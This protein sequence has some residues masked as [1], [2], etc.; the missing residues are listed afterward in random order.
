MSPGLKARCTTIHNTSPHTNETLNKSCVTHTGDHKWLK[1][2]LDTTQSLR[3][4]QKLFTT[5]PLKPQDLNLHAQAS[6]TDYRPTGFEPML[7]QR[8]NNQIN[9]VRQA[10]GFE[11]LP[12]VTLYVT[13]K[14]FAQTL[15]RPKGLNLCC[16]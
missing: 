15:T 11:P 3:S 9:P 1:H 8:N 4:K 10:K 13:K 16:L 7:I 6:K 2:T 5:C 12:P 14:A